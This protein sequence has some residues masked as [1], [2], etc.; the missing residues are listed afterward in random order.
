MC[1]GSDGNPSSSRER[2]E[3]VRDGRV[4]AGGATDV[5]VQHRVARRH[6]HEP[7]LLIG[8]ALGRGLPGAGAEG[9][10]PRAPGAGTEGGEQ[11]RPRADRLVGDEVRIGEHRRIGREALLEPGG[12]A[13]RAVTDEGDAAAERLDVGAVRADLGNLLAAEDAAEMTEPNDHRRVVGPFAGQPHRG[14]PGIEDGCRAK[15]TCV[16]GATYSTWPRSDSAPTRRTPTPR[17]SMARR[18]MCS[19]GC[20][21]DARASSTL[22]PLSIRAA[23][24]R[25]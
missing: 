22:I 11:T 7:S 14:A 3:D 1:S 17:S 2:G 16:H 6:D 25:G 19:A 13:R 10:N 24:A 23:H 4:V 12:G 15:R 21:T 8:V 20:L 5:L 18:S 9:A